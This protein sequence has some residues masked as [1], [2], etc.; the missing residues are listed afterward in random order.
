MASG[1]WLAV[2][3]TRTHTDPPPRRRHGHA[4]RTN[5]PGLENAGIPS[6]GMPMRH[7]VTAGLVARHAAG[8]VVGLLGVAVPA[9][10]VDRVVQFM[11]RGPGSH[12]SKEG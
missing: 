4:D 8:L 7:A 9:A 5:S 11:V 1:C 2:V 3:R 6:A 12:E 10:A